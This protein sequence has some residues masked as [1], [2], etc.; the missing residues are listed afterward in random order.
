MPRPDFITQEDI[1]RWLDSIESDST[2]PSE[3]LKSPIIIEVC[4]AG[5]WLCEELD[6]LGCHELITTRIQWTAGKL[7]YGKDPWEVH[8]MILEKYKDN[9][10]II[11]NDEEESESQLN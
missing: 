6:K 9:S 4:L 5:L 7:S 3:I 1:S 8:Q 2:I 11:E 10:L